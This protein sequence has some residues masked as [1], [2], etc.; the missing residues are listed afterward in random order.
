MAEES[1]LPGQNEGSGEI[2][3]KH[4]EPVNL[5]V[6]EAEKRG[7]DLAPPA[8]ELAPA[9]DLA[10]L[11][12]AA[13][14][15]RLSPGEEERA[16]ANMRSCIEQGGEGIHAARCTDL[17]GYMNTIAARLRKVRVC[18]G[19]WQ[20]VITDGATAHGATVGVFLD[21]PDSFAV[22]EGNLYSEDCTH[23]AQ[24]ARDWAISKGDDPRFRIV[25]AGY[26]DE[27]EEM[28]PATWRRLRWKSSGAY[29]GGKNKDT[30]T[31]KNRH[32][33]CLWFS[34]HCLQPAAMELFENIEEFAES[35]R[36][37]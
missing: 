13:T 16:T 29:A 34:P 2:K 23:V 8:T 19:D 22:R 26:F 3:S 15:G 35:G 9:D 25:L 30:A 10:A 1:N 20:R 17:Y 31:L 32:N 28:I 6:I 12:Q 33:E 36:E 5:A 14:K 18:C 11:A 27:H 21:P 37:K 4:P 24:E 7:I